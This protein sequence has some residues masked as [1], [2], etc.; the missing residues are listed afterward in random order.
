MLRHI[1]AAATRAYVCFS[2]CL[3]FSEKKKEPINPSCILWCSFFTRASFR[4]Q[5]RLR[6]QRLVTGPSFLFIFSAKKTCNVL[7][8]S[9]V[10]E[11]ARCRVAI[12]I[13]MCLKKKA[14]WVFSQIDVTRSTLKKNMRHFSQKKSERARWVFRKHSGPERARWDW[15]TTMRWAS[16]NLLQCVEKWWTVLSPLD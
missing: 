9:H 4:A 16:N 11:R 10:F 14:Q 7:S 15:A 13:I 3:G 1:A 2:L 12:R 8:R 5:C 6:A